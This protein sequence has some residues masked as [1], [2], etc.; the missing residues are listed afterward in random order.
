MHWDVDGP[1]E[2]YLDG[3]GRP[4]HSTEEICPTR[5]HTY[6]LMIV[7]PN[8]DQASFPLEIQVVGVLPLTLS[9]LVTNVSCD[10]QESY[11]AE[12]SIWASGGDGWYTYYR[13]DP[14]KYIGGPTEGGMVYSVSWRTCGGSCRAGERHR[15]HDD[16]SHRKPPQ[17]IR[18]R[19]GAGKTGGGFGRR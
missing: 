18:D 13:D 3:K 5:T 2:V 1:R 10:T 9:V 6:V 8:G 16:D 12:I 17:E 15:N 19:C 14:E 7:M 4:G 11:A